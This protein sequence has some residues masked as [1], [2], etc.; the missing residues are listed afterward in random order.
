LT[1]KRIEAI[2]EHIQQ[3]IAVI[4]PHDDSRLYRVYKEG[5]ILG[6]LASIFEKDP[7]M[8]REFLEH[9]EKIAQKQNKKIDKHRK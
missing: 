4:N 1:N 3:T 8:Y 6:H 5:F 7:I 2:A 9:C